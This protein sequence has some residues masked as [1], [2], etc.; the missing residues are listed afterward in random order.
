MRNVDIKREKSG[1]GKAAKDELV[2]RIDLNAETEIS[3]SEKSLIIG[4]THGN[5]QV[6]GVTIGVNC[7]RKNPDYKK[8]EK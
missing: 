8:K 2:I 1:T 3:E 5:I 4:T 6:E 7:Y